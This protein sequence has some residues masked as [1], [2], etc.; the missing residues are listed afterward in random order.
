[1]KKPFLRQLAE[2]YMEKGLADHMFV[3]PNR[4]SI[5]FFRKY[6]GEIIKDRGLPPQLSP[7]MMSV[8]EFFMALAGRRTADRVSLLLKLY[9]CY[10]ACYREKYKSEP[11]SLDEFIFWG[12][13]VLSDF[14]DVD[15]YLVD[16]RQLFTN[17]ADLT[18]LE[19]DY[20]FLSETQRAAIEKLASNFL[21]EKKENAKQDVKGKFLRSWNLLYELYEK[22][23]ELLMEAGIADEG[24]G[25]RELAGKLE[26]GDAADLLHGLEPRAKK[27]VIAG[28][29]ALSASEIKILE[30]LQKAAVAEFC[31]DF[32]GP[33]LDAPDAPDLSFVKENIKRFPSAFVVE[34]STEKPRIHVCSVP[35]ATGQ[36][37]LLKHIMDEIATEDGVGEKSADGSGQKPTATAIDTAI[38]LPD[39]SMLLPVL[40][41]LPSQTGTVNVTM[42]YTLGTSEWGALMQAVINMQLHLRGDTFYHKQVYDIFSS[43]IVKA[44]IGDEERECIAEV[45]KAAKPY[46]PK[47]DLQKGEVFKTVFRPVV[48][49]LNVADENQSTALANYLGE[50]VEKIARSLRGQHDELLLECAYRYLQCTRQ[51]AGLSLNLKPKNVARL[52]DSLTARISVPF[53]GEPLK[54]LQIMGPLETR[55]L[56]FRHLVVLNANEGVFPGKAVGSSFVPAE[57]RK[58]FG[59]PT[60]EL[61]DAIWTYYF[62]RMICRADDVWLVYDSRTEGLTTGEESRF[63]KQLRYLYPHKCVLID[64]VASCGVTASDNEN[65]S[66]T[67]EDIERIKSATY[68]ASSVHKYL[69]CPMQFYYSVVKRLYPEDEVREDMDKGMLGTVCHDT[70]QAIYCCD[71]AMAPDYFFD[72]IAGDD[73]I[74]GKT[75]GPVDGTFL[76]YWLG[77]DGQARVRTKVEA[78]MRHYLHATVLEG[79]N[80]VY[81]EVAIRYVTQVL[82]KDLEQ[83]KEKGPLTVLAVE[84]NL[85]GEICGH[86]FTGYIDRLDYFADGGYVRVV[87]YKTGKDSQEVLDTEKPEATAKNV[88]KG[89]YKVKA[90]FQFYVYDKLLLSEKEYETAVLKNAMY[91]LTEIF[92][93]AVKTWDCSKE[94]MAEMETGLQEMFE[95]L[96]NKEVKFTRKGS[97][98]DKNCQYCDYAVLCGIAKK[99]K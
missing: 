87:D 25:Y 22:F 28:L 93:K 4:R 26:T 85:S 86:K 57:L 19:G 45:K 75:V 96:E 61:Q 94:L 52:L 59:L 5:V 10:V 83:I 48:K 43:G 7:R 63:V 82:K 42:G 56:D 97:T 34:A 6:I 38:V 76:G 18:G 54:G 11:E 84:K 50:V 70:L 23:Y 47:D 37:K 33:F 51:I 14:D 71:A 74:K 21:K 68:S 13:T 24:M 8:N 53:A 17:I 80:L 89:E 78:L 67:D 73:G 69:S 9:D 98:W 39:E 58:A 29:N 49:D 60:Y 31:W 15:K 99:D 30:A 12:D 16:A 65:I 77:K 35:S 46:I 41:N 2:H 20:S 1:M 90:A 91:P 95:K 32:A 66:K 62:Y 3:F 64:E 92:T 44:A 40:D 88:F 79:R 81:V 36:T 72:K 27:C 55:A